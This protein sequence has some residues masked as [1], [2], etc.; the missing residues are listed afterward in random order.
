MNLMY[1]VINLKKE[2]IFSLSLLLSGCNSSI[3]TEDKGEIYQKK[4]LDKNIQ[5]YSFNYKETG[6]TPIAGD[7]WEIQV[8]DGK[9]I[10]VNYVGSGNP[11]PSLN[12]DSAPTIDLLFKRIIDC[13]DKSSCKVTLVEFDQINFHPVQYHASYGVEGEGFQVSHFIVQ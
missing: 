6:F 12:Q 11:D 5:S 8:A 3:S 4:W 9:V 2:F 1:K 10:Y 13:E 7:K